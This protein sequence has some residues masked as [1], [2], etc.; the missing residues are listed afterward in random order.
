M[1]T[2]QPGRKD[3]LL[4]VSFLPL[5]TLG[6]GSRALCLILETREMH[7]LPS[8]NNGREFLQKEKIRPS[9]H[10][11]LLHT[12]GF[13][14]DNT[15][16]EAPA[17]DR[18]SLRPLP[19]SFTYSSVSGRT[20]G[21]LASFPRFLGRE[22]TGLWLRPNADPCQKKALWVEMALSPESLLL[23]PS[24]QI[25]LHAHRLWFPVEAQHSGPETSP[26]PPGQ[27]PPA[28]RQDVPYSHGSP[29]R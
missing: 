20:D 17:E 22:V 6:S 12:H 2:S 1:K 25:H 28:S 13:V 7:A 27:L 21:V 3:A 11:P 4:Q 29:R 5:L 19:Y 18:R 24:L 23:H 26:P 16:R 15:G 9:R 10:L 14:G 8:P